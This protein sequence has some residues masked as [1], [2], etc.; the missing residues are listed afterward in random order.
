MRRAVNRVDFNPNF[1]GHLK[2]GTLF[3]LAWDKVR[4]LKLSD[5]Q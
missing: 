4:T 3:D 1:I 5:A 2:N